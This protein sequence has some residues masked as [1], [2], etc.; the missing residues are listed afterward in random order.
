MSQF[1]HTQGCK[2][3][4]VFAH[5]LILLLKIVISSTNSS[6]IPVLKGPLI[7]PEERNNSLNTMLRIIP[8]LSPSYIVRFDFKPT[9]FQRGYTNILHLTA[10]GDDCCYSGDRV[11]GV[12]FH[13][14]WK[15]AE[16]NR[17]RVCSAVNGIGNYC[18]NSGDLVQRDQWTTVE[19]SQR[20][21]GQFYIYHVKVGGIYLGAVWNRQPRFFYDVKVFGF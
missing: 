14:T 18:L 6:G 19:I 9:S 13:G 1:I 17:I 7:L 8:R 10:T 16:K 2:L 21:D 5:D 3:V 15:G 11:P 20:P 4:T 12:W